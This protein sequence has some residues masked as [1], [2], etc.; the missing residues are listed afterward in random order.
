MI[1][2]IYDPEFLARI[3]LCDSC[4]LS[5]RL[6]KEVVLKECPEGAVCVK[7]LDEREVG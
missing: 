7:C 3:R 5:Q 1:E 2:M 6:S 4:M